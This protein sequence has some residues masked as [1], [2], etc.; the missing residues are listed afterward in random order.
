MLCHHER[1][2]GAGYP[3][4]LRETQIPIGARIFAVADTLDAICSMRPYRAA[5]PLSVARKEIDAMSGTQFDPGVVRSF[6]LVADSDL[7]AIQ[8]LYAESETD[9]ALLSL[10]KAVAIQ[11]LGLCNL[12]VV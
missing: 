7:Q 4:R 8:R 5:S 1:F 2:D 3:N 6:Q 11:D 10:A 12:S 9:S